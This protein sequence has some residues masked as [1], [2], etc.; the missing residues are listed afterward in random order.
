MQ[1]K[2]KKKKTVSHIKMKLK[3]AHF[4]PVLRI[5]FDNT[6]RHI[7]VPRTCLGFSVVPPSVL[8]LLW[9]PKCTVLSVGLLSV[10][11]LVWGQYYTGFSIGEATRIRVGVGIRPYCTGVGLPHKC[12]GFKVWA[13]QVYCF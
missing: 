6:N 12:L 8:V 1:K 10:L 7:F 4:G 13:H 2:E 3:D 11:V 5:F 9:S